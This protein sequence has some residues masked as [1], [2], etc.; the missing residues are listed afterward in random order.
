MRHEVRKTGKS[1]STRRPVEYEEFL[2]RLALVQANL[3]LPDVSRAL[4][5]SVLKAQWH[6]IA[7]LD[8]RSPAYPPARSPGRRPLAHPPARSPARLLARLLY[9]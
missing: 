7:R 4:L 5:A 8:D 3:K 6:L 1:S 2:Q 9:R